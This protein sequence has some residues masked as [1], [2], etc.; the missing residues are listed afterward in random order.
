MKFGPGDTLYMLILTLT[1][2]ISKFFSF[3]Y[4]G[5]IWSQNLNFFKLTEIWYIGRF[6]CLFFQIFYHSCSFSVAFRKIWSQKLEF[7]KMTEVWYFDVYFFKVLII[8]IFGQIRSQKLK[9]SIL[10]E[11]WRSV[12]SLYA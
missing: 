12:A 11:I 1:L 6:Y 7:F 9:F 2:I 5:K 3:I 10:T 8:P 4:L